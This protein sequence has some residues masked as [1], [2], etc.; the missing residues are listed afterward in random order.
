MIIGMMLRSRMDLRTRR[1]QRRVCR[2]VA[3]CCTQM[4]VQSR[5]WL[6]TG[7]QVVGG[8]MCV[9]LREGRQSAEME[10]LNVRVLVFHPYS[11]TMYFERIGNH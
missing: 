3:R 9:P 1:R 11:M 6:C 5:S 2:A 7:L 4:T 10:V 8:V